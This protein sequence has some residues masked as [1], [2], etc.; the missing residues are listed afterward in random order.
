M[1]DVLCLCCDY[2][3]FCFICTALCAFAHA[4]VFLF[5][6]Y[7]LLSH[8]SVFFAFERVLCL[9]SSACPSVCCDLMH[10]PHAVFHLFVAVCAAF[11][12]ISFH[13][14]EFGTHLLLALQSVCVCTGI[15]CFL[16]PM[17]L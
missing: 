6:F 11:T 3:D 10:H 2:L 9:P 5:Y 8:V 7:S 13:V 1:L 4:F 16:D 12:R 15:V 17:V 14:R